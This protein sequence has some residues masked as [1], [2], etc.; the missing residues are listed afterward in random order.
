MRC[1][2]ILGIRENATAE[3]I[4]A[5]YSEKIE[6]LGAGADV[7]GLAAD[8]RKRSELAQAR[9]MCLAWTEKKGIQRVTERIAE[10]IIPRSN[11]LRTYALCC[12]P[13][14]LVNNLCCIPCELSDP[15]TLCIALAGDLGIYAVLGHA[16]YKDRQF[17]KEVNEREERK[18]LAAQAREEIERLDDELRACR[19]AQYDWKD[20]VY[21]DQV[22]L[23]YIRA[24][25]ELFEALGAENTGDLVTAQEQRLNRSRE[26]LLQLQRQENEYCTEIRRQR[27]KL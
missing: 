13:M 12:G 17:W 16:Y 24:Y 5:A 1:H 8:E 18:R 2:D 23:D 15:G 14:T 22:H 9:Q 3:Q 7:L 21:E 4:E 27:S 25:A 26:N 20:R 19:L 11:E 10:E 6:K